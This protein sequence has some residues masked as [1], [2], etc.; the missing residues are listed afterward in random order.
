VWEGTLLP[1]VRHGGDPLGAI[2]GAAWQRP[3]TVLDEDEASAMLA[4]E[5]R[6]DS[7]WPFAFDCS[8]TLRLHD[9]GLEMTLALTNQ[10]DRPA[11][12]GLGWRASFASR[13]GSRI[14][15]LA[16]SQWEFDADHL[17]LRRVAASGV[18]DDSAA[19][20]RQACF[21]DWNGIVQVDDGAVRLRLQSGL[22]RLVVTTDAAGFSL[23][24]VSHV[25]NAVHLHA[26]GAAT[27]DLGL[28][29][30]QPGESLVAQWRI[31]VE[32]AA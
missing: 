15:L 27:A 2:H 29:I 7:A 20:P 13:P 4:Y 16:D 11:P 17:P 32:G 10:S 14:A 25:P 6:P 3:W 31:A 30:L 12:A 19:L 24:P 22:K 21:D 8:H 28:A 23:A 9:E 1:H 18:Q 5:H 26:T